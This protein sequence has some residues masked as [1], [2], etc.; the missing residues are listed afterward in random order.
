[1]EEQIR[2]ANVFSSSVTKSIYSLVI[3]KDKLKS[4]TLKITFY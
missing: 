2:G 1:M 3:G 4:V